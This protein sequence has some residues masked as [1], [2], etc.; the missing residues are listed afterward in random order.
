MAA[1]AKGHPNLGLAGICLALVLTTLNTTA[2]NTALPAIGNEYHVSASLLQW[3]VSVYMLS[4]AAFVVAGGQLGD[5]FG[6]R[7]LFLFG[8]VGCFAMASLMVGLATSAEWVVAGR[9]FQGLGA[10]FLLPGSMSLINSLFPPG[11]RA[12][13]MGIWSAIAALGFALGPIVG[14]ILT[15][16][17]GW[18]WLWWSNLPVLAVATGIILAAVPES[19]DETR[20]KTVDLLGIVTLAIGLFLLV[21]VLDQSQVWGLLSAATIGTLGGAVGFLLLFAY[22]ERRHASPLIRPEAFRNRIFVVSNVLTFLVN[23]LMLAILLILNLYLQNYLLLDYTAVGAGL[24]LMPMNILIFVL[25]LKSGAMIIRFP[26]KRIII[27][28]FLF[29]IAGFGLLS[30]VHTGFGY[31]SYVLPFIL[32]GLGFGLNFSTV[33]TIG[34]AGVPAAKIGEASGLI[35]MS[36]Y[37]GAAFGVTLSMAVYAAG[38]RQLLNEILVRSGLPKGETLHLDGILTGTQATADKL[39]TQID[40]GVRPL[41]LADAKDAVTS[42]FASTMRLSVA[43]A[44]VGLLATIWLLRARPGQSS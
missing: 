14:G 19:R 5:I 20:A 23:W 39:L 33:S 21:F 1:V 12:W 41:V 2:T 18:K 9:I 17:F 36:R 8:G 6:R 27:L 29:L 30:T 28:G 16:S 38:G 31:G 22:L 11:R 35:N 24:A 13:A 3:I 26:V 15:D 44:V 7:K 40:S 34:M 43:V 25:A 4:C 32:L 42:A 37:L 10:A